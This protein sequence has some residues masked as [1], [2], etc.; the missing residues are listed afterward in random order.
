MS[1][2]SPV[3]LHPADASIRYLLVET[4]QILWKYDDVLAAWTQIPAPLPVERFAL[5]RSDP[6]VL[7]IVGN[8]LTET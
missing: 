1:S 5:S 7:A 6:D 3:S 8:G 2:R 4:D